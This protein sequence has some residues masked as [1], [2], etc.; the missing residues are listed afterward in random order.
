MVVVIALD[1]MMIMMVAG[2]GLLIVNIVGISSQSQARDGGRLSRETSWVMLMYTD[3]VI[4]LMYIDEVMLMNNDE[5]LMMA[6][7][8]TFYCC[9]YK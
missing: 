4:A 2:V 3:A 8:V 5:V 6:T 1:V 7:G 9:F